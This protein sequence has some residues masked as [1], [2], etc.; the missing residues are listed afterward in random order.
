[1]ITEKSD[2]VIPQTWQLNN[3]HCHHE[4]SNLHFG[5]QVGLHYVPNWFGHLPGPFSRHPTTPSCCLSHIQLA[6]VVASLR[7][8]YYPVLG[9][10][11]LGI[12]RQQSNGTSRMHTMPCNTTV[13]PQDTSRSSTAQ[14][15]DSDVY[16]WE[17]L[18]K[19]TLFLPKT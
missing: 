16:N 12:T 18:S 6:S 11:T 1:M 10:R 5:K 9:L 4:S 14:Q 13:A 8:L 3:P 17:C 19:T 2:I 15:A 7:D